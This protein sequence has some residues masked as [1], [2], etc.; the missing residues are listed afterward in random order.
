METKEHGLEPKSNGN[1]GGLHV[2]LS[3]VFAK[4]T[5]TS[6]S[7][8]IVET[9]RLLLRGSYAHFTF[10]ESIAALVALGYFPGGKT[11]LELKYLFDEHVLLL[12]KGDDSILDQIIE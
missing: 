4:R 3:D 11:Q 7:S 1:I 10:E 2:K 12:T 5:K 9:Y 8:R 6:A